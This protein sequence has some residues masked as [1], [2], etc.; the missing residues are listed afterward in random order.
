V[1]GTQIDP[2]VIAESLQMDTYALSETLTVWANDALP[3]IGFETRDLRGPSSLDAFDEQ[4]AKSRR[5]LEAAHEAF[6][7]Y[8]Q[9]NPDENDED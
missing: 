1:E 5:Y 9:D 6:K 4:V 3:S 2:R 8:T 7:A